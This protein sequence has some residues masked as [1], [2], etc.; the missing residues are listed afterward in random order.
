METDTGYV[1]AV[2][3]FAGI[4][5]VIDVELEDDGESVDPLKLTDDKALKLFPFKSSVTAEPAGA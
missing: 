4:T 1:P 5:T 2:I 3:R